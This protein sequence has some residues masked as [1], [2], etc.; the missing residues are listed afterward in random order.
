MSLGRGG[1][2]PE[3]GHVAVGLGGFD[4]VRDSVPTE[5]RQF[6]ADIVDESRQGTGERLAGRRLKG[7]TVRG[8]L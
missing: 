7:V 1:G 5:T 8:A 3:A 2:D 4:A 6:D